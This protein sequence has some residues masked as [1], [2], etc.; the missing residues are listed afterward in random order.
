MKD[1]KYC[2]KC[3]REMVFYNEDDKTNWKCFFCGY[4]EE[5]VTSN[6]SKA[7]QS[8]TSKSGGKDE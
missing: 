7:S 2:P 6:N 5:K 3:E 8:D 1:K 4:V